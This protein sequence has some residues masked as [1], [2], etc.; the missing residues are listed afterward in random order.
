MRKFFIK[1]CLFLPVPLLL[2]G[3]N[4]FIDPANL[5]KSIKYEKG[6]A[7]ILLKGLNVANISNWD[8]RLVQKYYIEGLREKK[9]IVVFGSS[10]AMEINAQLFPEKKN[11]NNS[12]SGASIEDYIAIYGLYY[13]KNLL[14][15][16]IIIGLDPWLLNRNNEQGRWKTISKYYNFTLNRMKLKSTETYGDIAKYKELLSPSY[17][18]HSI[19]RLFEI[20]K[21]PSAPKK[22]EYYQTDKTEADVPIKLF[23]GSYSYDDKIRT[24]SVSEVK[25]KAISYATS[26]PIYSLGQF[27]K[28]DVDYI[29]L[30]ESFI[31]LIKNDNIK[32]IFYLTPYHPY[33]YEYMINSNEY[34]IIQ[35]TQKYFEHLAIKKNIRLL[36]SYN[37][38]DI[39]LTEKDF[40]DGMHTKFSSVKKIF[41]KYM[42]VKIY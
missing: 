33:V 29:K 7:E 34:K 36:G 42:K 25:K 19:K 9:D 23:D 10:R 41:E 22:G 13:T 1:I 15:S 16:I 39:S 24:M 28:L 37:P 17:F 2:I 11:F 32:V 14:P 26:K 8:E 21:K 12:V 6:I 40:Y 30:L 38:M 27:S 3:V 20:I 4:Y 18:Q 35:E 5:F 31:D